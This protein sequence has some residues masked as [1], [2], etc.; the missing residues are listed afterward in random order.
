METR[1]M[2]KRGYGNPFFMSRDI[3]HVVFAMVAD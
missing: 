1:R 2:D 3:V